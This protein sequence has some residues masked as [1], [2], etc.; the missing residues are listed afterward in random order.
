MGRVLLLCS[1]GMDSCVAGAILGAEGQ[2]LAL[3]HIDYGQCTFGAESRAIDACSRFLAVESR[4]T[5]DLSSIGSYGSGSLVSGKG[6]EHYPH[7]NLFLIAIGSMIA[8]KLEISEVALGVID[9][10]VAEFADCRPSF[11]DPLSQALFADSP[12]I[13]LSMPLHGVSKQEVVKEA[14]RLG[15]PYELTFS[16]NVQSGRHCWRCRSCVERAEAH[17]SLLPEGSSK[18]W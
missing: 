7:R 14:V 18:R 4:T 11:V 15:F 10:A 1:G 17:N 5:L 2:S 13:K 8:T 16:C 6:P 3:L 12:S 9:S